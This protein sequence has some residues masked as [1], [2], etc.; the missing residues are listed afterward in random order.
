MIIFISSFGFLLIIFTLVIIGLGIVNGFTSVFEWLSV[1]ETGF[2]IGVLIVSIIASVIYTRF[3]NI[4]DDH[5]GSAG[6]IGY[7]NRILLIP[8]AIV[9][10][11]EIMV[12]ILSDFSDW[13]LLAILFLGT[14]LVLVTTLISILILGFVYFVVIRG[15]EMIYLFTGKIGLIIYTVVLAAIEFYFLYRWQIFW[16]FI[17]M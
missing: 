15:S 4:D 12:S 5:R 17:D 8:P 11:V 3:L 13:S 16:V 6:I 2:M 9:A 14:L 10:S 7:I 1:H